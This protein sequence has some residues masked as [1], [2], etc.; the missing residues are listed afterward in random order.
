MYQ[1][2]EFVKIDIPGPFIFFRTEL[3]V[4]DLIRFYQK[5]NLLEMEG[6]LI[7]NIIKYVNLDPDKPQYHNVLYSNRKLPYS[8]V[9]VKGQWIK[10]GINS[11][12]DNLIKSKC[13]C[14]IYFL[15]RNAYYPL[16]EDSKEKIKD[17]LNYLVVYTE[18]EQNRLMLRIKRLLYNNR[19]IVKKTKML[20]MNR[21]N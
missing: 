19:D 6:N 12:V 17:A 16:S 1:N 21:T 7:E 9:Y 18:K 15:Q 5:R 14:I 3:V 11:T 8:D 10:Q 4:I 2:Y 13:C 20:T